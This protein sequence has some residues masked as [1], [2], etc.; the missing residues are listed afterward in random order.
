MPLSKLQ[1]KRRRSKK[2]GFKENSKK[3]ETKLKLEDYNLKQQLIHF[4]ERSQNQMLVERL[5][6]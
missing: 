5:M 1:K 3:K 6:L 2:Q 4:K